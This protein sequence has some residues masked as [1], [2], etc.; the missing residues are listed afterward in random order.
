VASLDPV[1]YPERL[2]INSPIPI[3]STTPAATSSAIANG[4]VPPDVLDGPGV[5]VA[6]TPATTM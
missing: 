4:G 6:G 3:S 2:R 1:V 5:V